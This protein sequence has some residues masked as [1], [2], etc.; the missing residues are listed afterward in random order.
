[1]SSCCESTVV[2]ANNVQAVVVANP[3]SATIV[4]CGVQGLSGTFVAGALTE[5]RVIELIQ[6]SLHA[7][8]PTDGVEVDG[9]GNIRLTLGT[10]PAL[11]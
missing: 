6:E 8:S 3:N 2:V 10:L 5:N 7:D 11:P 9:A 4:T 1:V